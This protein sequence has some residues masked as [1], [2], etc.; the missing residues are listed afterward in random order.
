MPSINLVRLQAIIFFATTMPTWSG[1]LHILHEASWDPCSCMH[2]VPGRLQ[3]LVE[4]A[5]SK[6]P[7]RDPQD[8]I[9]AL[10]FWRII[11]WPH[12]STDSQAPF[13]PNHNIVYFF[14]R[15]HCPDEGTSSYMSRR[16]DFSNKCHPH[17]PL[18]ELHKLCFGPT[19]PG[20]RHVLCCPRPHISKP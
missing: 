2:T 4:V 18:F 16:D 20:V 12:F 19:A 6:L 14:D 1:G 17:F 3:E 10:S 13:N 9:C 5:N 15:A 7:S 8:H 11:F